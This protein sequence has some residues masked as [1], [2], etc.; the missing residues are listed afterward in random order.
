VSDKYELIAAQCADH[1]TTAVVD[2]PT[3]T[4]MCV[5]IEVS[6]SG[7][8][9]W[10]DRPPSATELR[11]EELDIEIKRLFDASDGTYGYRRI[12]V[13]LLRAGWD[14]GEEQVRARMRW[15]G[16]V[17]CQPRPYK[18]TTVAGGESAAPDLVCR[19]FAADAPG[20]KLVGDITYIHTWEGWLYL[21]TV[22]DCF[23]KEVVG[24]AMADHMRA[25]LVVDALDMAAR[26]HNLED[27]CIFH[28]DRG[29]QYT[30]S[31]FVEALAG[32]NMKQSLGRTGSC[33]DNALAESFNGSLKVERVYRTAYPTRN[34][35]K[36]DVA[37]Y[38]EI[39]YNHKR[40]HSGIGYRTPHE[41]RN[42]YLNRQQAA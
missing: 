10:R 36:D 15:L 17:A 32:H 19:V 23:N 24:Y 8:Y 21:A 13:E 29:S 34:A 26:N 1:Q 28:S 38:I 9:E 40:I 42:E 30:S 39:F 37:R 14:V 33:Y 31:E 41:V 25:G 18:T 12:H 27:E 5:W 16:L 22:I 3:I 7:F 2:A 11:H 20:T 4:Q 6:R 35:A